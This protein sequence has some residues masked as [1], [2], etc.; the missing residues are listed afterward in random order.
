[1]TE[2][3]THLLKPPYGEKSLL[4]V[5]AHPDDES[6]GPGGTLAKYAQLGVNV[7]Y[8]CATRGEAGTVSAE[9]LGKHPDIASLRTAELLAAA[10]HL[11]L[12]G[13]HFLGWRDSGMAGSPDNQHPQC[14]V[15]APQTVVARQVL[16]LFEQIRPQVVVTF[17]PIGG[18]MHPDHIA[19]H[20][21]T[22][23][24]FQS[25]QTWANPP[26][27]LYYS[28]F[29]R[30]LLRWITRIMPLFGQN[31]KQFGRNKDIDITQF[32]KVNYPLHAKIDVRGAP[33]QAKMAAAACHASQAS[34]PRT[35]PARWVF[36]RSQEVESFMRAYPPAPAHLRETDLFAE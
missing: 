29:D 9:H 19:I 10:G 5:F 36:R 31:P 11:Q 15:Q 17:D 30:R 16:A 24:A 23:E 22:V 12:T 26:Q 7:H 25:A 13:V 35:G 33:L 8:A 1:M 4:F 27:K 32:A 3:T 14:L 2:I 6:F 20:K 21:A 28:T 34:P 18:Y